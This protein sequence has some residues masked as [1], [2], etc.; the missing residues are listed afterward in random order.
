MAALGKGFKG[1]CCN[2]DYRLRF[3]NVGEIFSS[4]TMVGV[5]TVITACGFVTHL[6]IIQDSRFYSCNSDYRLRFCNAAT[7]ILTMKI[8]PVA[9]V[10]TACGF[11]TFSGL[12]YA[13]LS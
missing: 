8:V 9:T 5:A 10:I 4:F 11:V 13:P 2:S 12:S 3:C 6:P 7:S 1:C